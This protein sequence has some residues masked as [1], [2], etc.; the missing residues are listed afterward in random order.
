LLG[1]GRAYSL[2]GV[3]LEVYPGLRS[4]EG[5]LGWKTYL[6]ILPTEEAQA[7]RN[8]CCP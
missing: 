3:R 2:H 8:L 7:R 5:G 6:T 1:G 4:K